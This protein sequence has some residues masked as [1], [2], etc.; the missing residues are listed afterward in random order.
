MEILFGI[1]L[2]VIGGAGGVLIER[3]KWQKATGRHRP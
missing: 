3:R 1:I 2:L